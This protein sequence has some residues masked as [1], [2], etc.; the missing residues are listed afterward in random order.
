VHYVAGGDV[1]LH[2]QAAPSCLTPEELDRVMTW[3][4]DAARRRQV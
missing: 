3:R 1:V 2:M 4:A